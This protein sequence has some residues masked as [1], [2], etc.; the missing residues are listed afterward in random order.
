MP[1]SKLPVD[2]LSPRFLGLSVDFIRWQSDAI[3]QA[4]CGDYSRLTG[5]SEVTRI[6]SKWP[7]I[8]EVTCSIGKHS[9][10]A[11]PLGALSE[12]NGAN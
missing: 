9:H 2:D 5:D 12:S 7:T 4:I 6:V 1:L 8:H 3:E 11:N 10:L